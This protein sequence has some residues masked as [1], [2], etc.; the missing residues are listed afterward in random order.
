[1]NYAESELAKPIE[2]AIY[3]GERECEH[4]TA[5]IS[6]TGC[7]R[8]AACENETAC[9][10]AIDALPKEPANNRDA[11]L[12]RLIAQE[13]SA[14]NRTN[15]PARSRHAATRDARRRDRAALLAKP[16]ETL[17]FLPL[18]PAIQNNGQFTQ[19]PY[20]PRRFPNAQRDKTAADGKGTSGCS[21]DQIA[22]SSRKAASVKST[23]MRRVALKEQADSAPDNCEL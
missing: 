17:R 1:M 8:E 18:D 13:L 15:S 4:E 19:N 21:E 20:A 3:S 10:R 5:C 7:D 16:V 22:G 23:A 2:E 12:E 14:A 6:Q 9:E 11:N